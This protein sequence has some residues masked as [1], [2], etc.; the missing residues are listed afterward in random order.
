MDPCASR[1]GMNLQVSDRAEQAAWP[2]WCVFVA[3]EE[4]TQL[5]TLLIWH[6][7]SLHSL[8]LIHPSFLS[9]PCWA[10][11]DRPSNELVSEHYLCCGSYGHGNLGET[12]KSQPVARLPWTFMK[13]ELLLSKV[14][15]KPVSPLEKCTFNQK[16]P[17]FLFLLALLI[18][19]LVPVPK[20]FPLFPTWSSG[21]KCYFWAAS[22]LQAARLGMFWKNASSFSGATEEATELKASPDKIQGVFTVMKFFSKSCCLFGA[23]VQWLFFNKS[24]NFT[25]VYL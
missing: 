12:Q 3:Y 14:L 4:K 10:F 1:P 8:I 18:H 15:L 21:T 16:S 9:F 23:A 22:P 11:P 13:M 24:F 2:L 19:F 17:L 6:P 25:W 7:D 5:H 20:S